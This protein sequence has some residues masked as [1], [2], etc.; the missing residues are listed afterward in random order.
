LRRQM[1]QQFVCR[2]A[3][4][5]F[6]AGAATPAPAARAQAVAT[7]QAA[8]DADDGA[9]P[10]RA[11]RLATHLNAM[12]ALTNDTVLG[13]GIGMDVVDHA[14]QELTGIF[15]PNKILQALLGT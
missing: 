13:V 1:V 9:D 2:S 14:L 15:L 12:P 7:A 6:N 11:G 5:G 10:A 4:R 8:V 3:L